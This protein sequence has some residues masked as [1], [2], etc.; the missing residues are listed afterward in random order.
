MRFINY[1]IPHCNAAWMKACILALSLLISDAQWTR[2]EQK[3][4]HAS[5]LLSMTNIIDVRIHKLPNAIAV[6]TCHQ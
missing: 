5:K 4:P 6:Q 2:L 1:L 3:E